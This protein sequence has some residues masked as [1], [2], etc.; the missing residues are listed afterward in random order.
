MKVPSFYA[1]IASVGVLTFIISSMPA[2][3]L[4]LK[5]SEIRGDQSPKPIAVLQKRYFTKAFRPEL[6][7]SL[8]Y[9]L[10]EA[11][12]NTSMVGIHSSLFFSEWVGGEIQY[13]DNSVTSSDDRKALNK[14]VFRDEDKPSKLVS[15]DPEI[16]AIYRVIDFNGIIAPFYGK[17]NFFN[18]LIIY[19]DFY[20][21]LGASHLETDQGNKLGIVAGA[22]Q[23][24][25]LN[26]T[27]SMRLDVR[28]RNFSE[29]RAGQSSR[30]NSLS[31]DFGVSYFFF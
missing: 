16:N 30:R 10:N 26:K 27:L 17:L 3:A 6:G 13:F 29:T 24:F 9:I 5:P 28:N 15:P 18:A 4:D 12:T 23:R 20:L 8:G 7:L 25:Y 14:L 22:G 1:R 2:V 21:T 31:V 19:M 11:Y